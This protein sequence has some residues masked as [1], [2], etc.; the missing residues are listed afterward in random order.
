MDKIDCTR[1]HTAHR[2]LVLEYLVLMKL[3]EGKNRLLIKFNNRYG[4][5]MDFGLNTA[6]P[7]KIYEL[8]LAKRNFT[9]INSCFLNMHNLEYLH[10]RMNN[11]FI[12][13]Y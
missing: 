10:Q 4:W 13:F 1:H 5:K 3:K 8:K 6:V 7:Q 9:G 12:N 11:F 2:D